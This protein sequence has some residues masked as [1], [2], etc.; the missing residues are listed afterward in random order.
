MHA[1][2]KWSFHIWFGI[3]RH[4]PLYQYEFFRAVYERCRSRTR[5][6]LFRK[7]ILL[8]WAQLRPG[9]VRVG[10]L[11]PCTFPP[12]DYRRA[13]LEYVARC[14]EL[15]KKG[16][17]GRFGLLGWLGWLD[18]FWLVC[19]S[20][21]WFVGLVGSIHWLYGEPKETSKKA[22][23]AKKS[24]FFREFL[25]SQNKGKVEEYWELTRNKAIHSYVSLHFEMI[26]WWL[27]VGH[28]SSRSP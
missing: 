14:N 24:G 13:R 6:L 23:S 11:N 28:S 18:W 9:A 21:R 10:N 15:P 25:M 5:P 22:F 16:G 26:Q 12:I 1:Y 19:W 17:W 7:K 8:Q 2:H 20:V 3:G 27:S 4:L